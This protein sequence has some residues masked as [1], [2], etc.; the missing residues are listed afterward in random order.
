M[1]KSDKHGISQVI[2]VN[3]NRDISL[4]HSMPLSDDAMK[5]TF[6]L[7]NLPFNNPWP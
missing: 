7:Y 1:E 6:Y 4:V 3:I 5:M 2:K